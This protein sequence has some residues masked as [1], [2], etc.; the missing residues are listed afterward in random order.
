MDSPHDRRFLALSSARS[1][2]KGYDSIAPLFRVEPERMAARLTNTI[3]ISR[4]PETVYRYVT[5]PWLWHQWHPNSKGAS[6]SPRDLRTGDTFQ[7]DIELQPLRP[8][9]FRMR[10]RM[11][12]TVKVAEPFRAWEAVGRGKDG[13]LD[14][15][16]EFQPS[17]EGTRFTRTLTFETRG[18]SALLMPFLRRRVVSESAVALDNL[19]RRLESMADER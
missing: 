19:K 3:E 17:R 7:E 2:G 14:L 13:W 11:S 6:R 18:P 16:Y 4:P 5:Q 1:A 12:Y 10:R 9:P 8:V 15:R